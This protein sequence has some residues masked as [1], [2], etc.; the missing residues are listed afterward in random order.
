M[1]SAMRYGEKLQIDLGI[2]ESKE[3]LSKAIKKS[4]RYNCMDIRTQW[5]K[6]NGKNFVTVT[7]E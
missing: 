5:P 1:L 6:P 3:E 4:A 2:A 7:I